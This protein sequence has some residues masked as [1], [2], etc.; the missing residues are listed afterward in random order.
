MKTLVNFNPLNSRILKSPADPTGV[1]NCFSNSDLVDTF[2]KL[3]PV[4]VVTPVLPVNCIQYIRKN[5]SYI[6]VQEF[7]PIVTDVYYTVSFSDI[8]RDMREHRD[9]YMRRCCEQHGDRCDGCEDAP[10][11][12]DCCESSDCYDCGY[13]NDFRETMDGYCAGDELIF[14]NVPSPR[15]LFVSV[16]GIQKDYYFMRK[17]FVKALLRPVMKP[18]DLVFDVPVGNLYDDSSVCWGNN[19][20]DPSPNLMFISSIL[21]RFY[22]SPF[23]ADLDPD[24]GSNTALAHSLNLSCFSTRYF[25]NA[26]QNKPS[27]DPEWLLM[28]NSNSIEFTYEEFIDEIVGGHTT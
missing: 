11:A 20:F 4:S 25:L 8:M 12:T 15:L 24:Y 27:F 9:Y 28:F 7:D 1:P 23:N 18:S 10:C 5:H 2:L 13:S 26:I 6:I 14:K 21:S 19:D 17:C 3:A 16:L 22:G